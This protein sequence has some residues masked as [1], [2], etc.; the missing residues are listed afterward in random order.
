MVQSE[1]RRN[2]AEKIA[3]AQLGL[4]PPQQLAPDKI[5]I[6]RHDPH[7]SIG[8]LRMLA[9]QLREAMHLLLQPV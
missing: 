1:L 8:V 6:L 2:A 3:G 7:Q 5:P 4:M 9:D